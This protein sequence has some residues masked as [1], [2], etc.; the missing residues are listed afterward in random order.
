MKFFFIII[1]LFLYVPS[2]AM[3]DINENRRRSIVFSDFS[4]SVKECTVPVGPR[5]NYFSASSRNVRVGSEGGLRLNIIERRG[6][7]YCSEVS[8]KRWRIRSTMAA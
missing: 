3:P 5:P 4:W 7:W 1:L 6:R 8:P 2:S